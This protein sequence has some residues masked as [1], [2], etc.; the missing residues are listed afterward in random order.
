WQDNVYSFDRPLGIGSANGYPRATSYFV[1]NLSI[2]Y[3]EEKA[4]SVVKT[5]TIYLA[6][7]QA[8]PPVV[9]VSVIEFYNAALDPYFIT[10]I[11]QEISDLDNGV[12]AGWAR[13]GQSFKAYDIGS[14]GPLDRRPVCRFYGSPAA[15][16]D[17]HFYSASVMECRDTGLKFAGAW[18]LEADE[19]FE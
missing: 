2:P 17:S 12:H 4:A 9:E 13:T 14:G 16:L 1:F 5:A 8:P 6:G 11:P 15:G 18:L 7:Y 3:K 19:V 10:S